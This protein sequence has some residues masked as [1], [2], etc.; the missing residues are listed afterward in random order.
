MLGK[1]F[2]S[3]LLVSVLGVQASDECK[4]FNVRT[5][6]ISKGSNQSD[7]KQD[8]PGE[9][10]CCISAHSVSEGSPFPQDWRCVDPCS[11]CCKD[12]CPSPFDLCECDGGWDCNQQKGSQEAKP[13]EK[14]VEVHELAACS[15]FNV[16]A[17]QPK[18]F[19]RARLTG[20]YTGLPGRSSLL[21]H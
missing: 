10:V 17:S 3:V 13:L 21:H 19:L 2:A 5:I 8:C 16:S 9:Q 18:L 11:D 7:R 15:S 6:P 1:H 20:S 4:T 12:H 14:L